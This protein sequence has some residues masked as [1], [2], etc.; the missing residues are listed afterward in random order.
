MQQ[1][2]KLTPKQLHTSLLA[3]IERQAPLGNLAAPQRQD[4]WQK[5]P[6][7]LDAAGI[8]RIRNAENRYRATAAALGYHWPGAT[9]GS[10]GLHAGEDTSKPPASK[11][12]PLRQAI[13]RTRAAAQLQAR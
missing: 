1:D 5:A 10:T 8:E 9:L 6:Q 13:A 7:F 11:Q 12:E 3:S 2:L 4:F